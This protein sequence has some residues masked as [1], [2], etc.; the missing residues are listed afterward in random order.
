MI[1]HNDTLVKV[2]GTKL[3]FFTNFHRVKH[4]SCEF[5]FHVLNIAFRCITRWKR[6]KASNE[7]DVSRDL[8]TRKNGLRHPSG[9]ILGLQFRTWTCTSSSVWGLSTSG[10]LEGTGP[11]E[12]QINQPWNLLTKSA[13]TLRGRGS[14]VKMIFLFV[15]WHSQF[16]FVD[17]EV[18]LNPVSHSV[19]QDLLYSDVSFHIYVCRHLLKFHQLILL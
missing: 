2:E 14:D 15:N 12:I 1:T 7:I 11:I 19:Y 4:K 16:E 9:T 3:S 6:R 18:V 10:Y 17:L 5:I 8:Q 13:I